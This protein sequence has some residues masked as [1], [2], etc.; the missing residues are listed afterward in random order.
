MEALAQRI[1]EARLRAGFS[2]ADLAERLRKLS[3]GDKA[4][5]GVDV[6]RWERGLNCPHPDTVALIAKACGTTPSYLLGEQRD[7]K[8]E[9]LSRLL[10]DVERLV[11]LVLEERLRSPVAA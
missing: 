5:S 1:R 4:T 7:V 8:T 2:Q 6:S 3:R 11:D 10:A 9:L